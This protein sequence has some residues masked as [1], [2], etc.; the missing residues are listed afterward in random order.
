M[1]EPDDWTPATTVRPLISKSSTTPATSSW[2]FGLQPDNSL[3]FAW[4]DGTTTWAVMGPILGIT[5]GPKWLKVT[6]DVNDG[7]GNRVVRFYSSDDG[8]DFTLLS[9]YTA[10][11]TTSINDSNAPVMIGA[12]S[13]GTAYLPG[14]FYYAHVHYV[15][16]GTTYKAK[17]DPADAKTNV[18]TSSGPFAE[19]WTIN[20]SGW[21]WVDEIPFES[22]TP[23]Q[24]EEDII[25]QVE[26][27]RENGPTIFIQD[28]D[29]IE[30]YKVKNY[31]VTDLMFEYDEDVY[32]RAEEVL[33][34]YSQPR[35]IISQ[36]KLV[37]LGASGSLPVLNQILTRKLLDR[38]SVVNRPPG[39]GAPQKQTSN[40]QG[41]THTITQQ[42]WE[43]DYE[44]R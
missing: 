24:G 37:G 2:N 36:L 4:S 41:I 19:V 7:A 28:E 22:V 40:I 23:N 29:S 25:N 11:G 9:T 27:A 5:S 33:T 43:T 16:G 8:D 35:I 38:V 21:S 42:R 17:F 6:L 31:S 18:W 39:G 12:Y 26:I 30:T 14:K 3:W 15:I 1:V 20:G 44:L 10:A 13:G 32:L 34:K